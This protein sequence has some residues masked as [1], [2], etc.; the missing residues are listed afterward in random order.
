MWLTI[1]TKHLRNANMLKVVGAVCEMNGDE[2][3]QMTVLLLQ[4]C[5][6]YLPH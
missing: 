3:G 2:W 5:L 6:C 4:S 1:T